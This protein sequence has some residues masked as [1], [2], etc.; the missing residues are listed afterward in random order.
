M[1]LAF[2]GMQPALLRKM[3]KEVL[4][5]IQNLLLFLSNMIDRSDSQH[6]RLLSIILCHGNKNKQGTAQIPTVSQRQCFLFS[7]T[8][9]K[10]PKL[11]STANLLNIVTVVKVKPFVFKA[12]LCQC[13]RWKDLV[14]PLEV[15]LWLDELIFNNCHLSGKKLHPSAFAC[16][17]ISQATISYTNMQTGSSFKKVAQCVPKLYTWGAHR[18]LLLRYLL[19]HQYYAND[20][21][22]TIYANNNL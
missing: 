1:S 3:S 18:T 16:Y 22:F 14:P 13:L 12:P 20:S 4:I 6:S 17:V 7:Y 10:T 11:F 2:S 21:Q 5:Q 19:P 8:T 9:L 15:L